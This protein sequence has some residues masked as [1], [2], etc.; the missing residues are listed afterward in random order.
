[1][2]MEKEKE[3]MKKEEADAKKEVDF[4]SGKLNNDSF[5]S[6]APAAV[7]EAEREKLRRAQ[8]RLAIIRESLGTL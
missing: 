5:V 3:R 8:D 2:D 4:L 1:M 7:V 6:R